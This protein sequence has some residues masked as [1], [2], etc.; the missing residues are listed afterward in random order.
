MNEARL[1]PL[2]PSGDPAFDAF[3]QAYPRHDHKFEARK[4]W[5]KLKLG[6]KAVDKLMAALDVRKG[7][8]DWREHVRTGH[9]EYIPLAS[10]WL[11]NRRFEDETVTPHA[12]ATRWYDDCTHEPPCENRTH[13]ELRK[14][15]EGLFGEGA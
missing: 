2:V 5:D 4:A 6:Q 11:N 15:R 7:R 9:L 13:H 10:T 8:Q 12:P 3:W 1:L 14:V